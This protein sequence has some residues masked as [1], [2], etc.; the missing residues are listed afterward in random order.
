MRGEGGRD[1][2]VETLTAR[3]VR[4]EVLELYRRQCPVYPAGLILETL[5]A[6]RLNAI[7]V[8]SGQGFAHLQACAGAD[9]PELRRYPLLVPSARVAELARAN[10]CH[11]VIECQG[12]NAGAIA[13]ALAHHHPD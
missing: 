5:A 8:S 10:G 1:L 6:E 3:G 9:W 2:L 13:A 11:R 4:V 7:M 12:A